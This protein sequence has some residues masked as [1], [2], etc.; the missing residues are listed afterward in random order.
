MPGTFDLCWKCQT[1]KDGEKT[2]DSEPEFFEEDL[3]ASKPD[4]Q[5]EPTDLDAEPYCQ[6]VNDKPTTLA[7][8]SLLVCRTTL[9]CA[10]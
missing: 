6:D 9:D 8:T 2:E 1:T 10:N 5:L 7:K 3:D 4:E